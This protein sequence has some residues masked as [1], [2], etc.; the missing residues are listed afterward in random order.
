MRMTSACLKQG[1]ELLEQKEDSPGIVEGNLAVILK[2]AMQLHYIWCLDACGKAL[3]HLKPGVR[4]VFSDDLLG[5]D[6]GTQYARCAD[7]T[8]WWLCWLGAYISMFK[9]PFVFVPSMG[10]VDI[11]IPIAKGKLCELARTWDVET[12]RTVMGHTK[13]LDSKFNMFSMYPHGPGGDLWVV[14]H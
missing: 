1:G 8:L 5:R 12:R 3:I 13:S 10:E 11:T 2:N 9:K 6:L 4:L 7:S 14:T